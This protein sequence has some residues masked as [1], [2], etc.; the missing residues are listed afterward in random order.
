MCKLPLL[1]FKTLFGH[2]FLHVFMSI[3]GNI[4][5]LNYSNKGYGGF[6]DRRIEI[7]DQSHGDQAVDVTLYLLLDRD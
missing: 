3:F 5:A 4:L 7:I 1:V 6:G 2:I